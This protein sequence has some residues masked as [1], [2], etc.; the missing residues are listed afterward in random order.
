MMETMMQLMHLKLKIMM[1]IIEIIYIITNYFVN[2][3]E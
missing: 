3:L 1:I 2:I